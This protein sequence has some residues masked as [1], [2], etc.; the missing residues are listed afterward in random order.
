M[1]KSNKKFLIMAGIIFVVI[2][3]T[4]IFLWIFVKNIQEDRV[5][6]L[7]TMEN[8]K[9]KYKAFSPMVEEFTTKRAS[10]YGMKEEKM[11]LESI[12]QNREEIINLMKEYESLVLK[13]HND[14]NY[15]E[16]NCKRKYSDNRV[17][18]TCNLFKQG[19][20]AVM[21]YY[22]TDLK[23]YNE[24]VE[25]YNTWAKENENETSLDI[26]SFSLY[27]NYIDYDQDGSYLGGK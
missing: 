24:F 12:E 19:Y 27:S 3:L 6:T 20:E 26:I 9:E 25:S 22:M 5:Q 16:E 2:I 14:N 7:K 10:F 11:Y 13:V 21:N 8:I 23:V 15:L 1:M 17:N 4:I 18:N